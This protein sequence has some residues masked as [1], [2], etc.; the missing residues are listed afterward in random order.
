MAQRKCTSPASK[1]VPAS[2]SVPASKPCPTPKPWNVSKHNCLSPAA[3][4]FV[5]DCVPDCVSEQSHTTTTTTTPS[6]PLPSENK[7]DP[8]DKQ[9]E[10]ESKNGVVVTIKPIPEKVTQPQYADPKKLQMV[11]C[12]PVSKLLDVTR[13][14]LFRTPVNECQCPNCYGTCVAKAKE[15]NLELMLKEYSGYLLIV[16][17][18]KAGSIV[19]WI[20]NNRGIR[21]ALVQ[22]MQVLIPKFVP[23]SWRGLIWWIAND[24]DKFEHYHWEILPLTLQ[25]GTVVEQG[26]GIVDSEGKEKF[27]MGIPLG[28]NHTVKIL[29]DK[30]D[31]RLGAGTV[32]LSPGGEDPMT[33]G[34]GCSVKFALA[35]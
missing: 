11:L 19:E 16:A 23:V 3:P 9:L 20:D 6:K 27:G 34:N 28:C 15:Q 5:P 18:L 12:A 22:D 8:L 33:A 21:L 14:P 31:F 29:P 30:C 4:E 1:A 25:T 10:F 32:M 13:N 7:C 24:G 26:M 35:I 17:T 2:K